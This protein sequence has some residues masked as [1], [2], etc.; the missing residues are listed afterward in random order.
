MVQN[1]IEQSEQVVHDLNA[2]MQ[3]R[4]T[5]RWDEGYDN[6]RKVWNGA[7]DHH[8]VA[9]AFCES[10]EDV[11]AAV[12]TAR[13]HNLPVSVRSRGHDAAGRSVRSDA[14]VIDLSPM[15]HV[16]IDD[17]VATVAGG[18]TAAKV[19]AAAAARNLMAVTGWNGVPGMT[20]LTTVGGYGPLIASHGL[21]LDSLTGAE[22]V[23]ADGQR[24]TVDRDKNPDLLWALKGGGGNFGVVTSMKVRLHPARQVLGGM[25]L[26]P[27]GEAETVLARC[28]KAIGS[29]SNNL[30]VVIGIISLPD[31]SPALFL[32]PAWTGEISDGDIAMEVLKRCGKPMHVQIASMGYQDLIQGFDARVANDKH[33]ALETRWIPALNPEAMSALIEG[34]ASRTSPFST[35]ILQHFRGLPTQFPLDSTAFGLR[36]EHVMVEIISCWDPTAGDNGSVHKRWARDFSQTLAPMSLPGGYPNLLG[37]HAQDQIAQAY[38]NNITRLQAVKRRFDPDGFFSATALPR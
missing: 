19:I 29:A 6:A 11:Q 7:V 37:P 32:A 10:A 9:I 18:A 3:G 2:K 23:L 4:V 21:A 28:G 30:S 13:A 27:W 14:L 36:R 20:G 8:P 31:G 25:I 12:R 1:V 33:Y 24:L 34:G 15:D 38:G 26:F 35:I 17:Q 5:A 16:R 22:L